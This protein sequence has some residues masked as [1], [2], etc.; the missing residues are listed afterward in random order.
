MSTDDCEKDF[1]KARMVSYIIETT[2][3]EVEEIIKQKQRVTR[4]NGVVP[5]TSTKEK[6]ERTA[7]PVTDNHL[8]FYAIPP[9]VPVDDEGTLIYSQKHLLNAGNQLNRVG[10]ADGKENSP[11]GSGLLGGKTSGKTCS[12][13]LQ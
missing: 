1:G 5:E 6:E 11:P 12:N 13:L 7:P 9:V 10:P 2:K 3:A 4:N 8:A